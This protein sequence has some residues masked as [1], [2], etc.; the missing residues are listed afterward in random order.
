MCGG[1]GGGS[2]VFV[3]PPMLPTSLLL[4]SLFM[5]ALTAAVPF[6]SS[7]KPKK[8]KHQDFKKNSTSRVLFMMRDKII[9]ICL[10]V[11]FSS[12]QQ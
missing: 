11:L 12:T 8:Q 5:A 7:K 4:P 10:H 6:P 1:G 2:L 9:S 3:W